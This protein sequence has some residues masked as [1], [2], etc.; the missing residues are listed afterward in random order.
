[1]D[2]HDE[3]TLPTPWRP[4]ATA[5]RDGTMVRLLVDFTDHA[6]EDSGIAATIG[7]CN[8][9]NVPEPEWTGWQFAGWC[10]THDHFTEGKG[11]PVGW[12]PMLGGESARAR[13]VDLMYAQLLQ[14]LG[15]NDHQAAAARIGELA[16]LELLLEAGGAGKGVT[17]IAQERRRQIAGEKFDPGADLQYTA[18]ELARAAWCYLGLAARDAS[19]EAASCPPEWPWARCWWKPKDTRSNLVRAGALIAAELDRI[20]RAEEADR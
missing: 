19:S 9:G 1:M 5:P 3:N 15:A 6:T 20:D 10:W 16:G 14:M 2:D 7:A 11:T 18:A 12:L 4:M 13:G 17:A 8:D